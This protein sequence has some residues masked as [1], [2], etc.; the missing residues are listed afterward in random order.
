MSYYTSGY[1]AA[2]VMTKSDTASNIAHAIYVGGTGDVAVVTAGGNSVIFS[3]VPA[4]TL[5][6][7]HIRQLLSTGTTATLIVGLS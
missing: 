6:P 3:A 4:G 7:I 2:V 5:I 1:S